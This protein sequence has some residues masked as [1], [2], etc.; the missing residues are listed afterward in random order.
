MTR[1]ELIELIKEVFNECSKTAKN[2]RKAK[3]ECEVVKEEVLNSTHNTPNTPNT[4][5]EPNEPATPA[6]PTDEPAGQEGGEGGEGEGGEGGEGGD[7]PK[8]DTEVVNAAPTEPTEV[9]T[10]EV[11]N[12]TPSTSPAIDENAEWKTLSGREL[13]NWIQTHRKEVLEYQRQ[14][15]QT[16]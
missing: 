16:H 8:N 3:N 9:V 12:S 10:E 14:Y 6:K 13:S 11:L 7:E 5:N 4:P 2:L 1:E 15:Y